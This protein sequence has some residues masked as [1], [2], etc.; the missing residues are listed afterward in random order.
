MINVDKKKGFCM[1]SGSGSDLL[2]EVA[3]IAASFCKANIKALKDVAG[4]APAA[5]KETESLLTAAIKAGCV[6]AL[7]S[8]GAT[9]EDTDDAE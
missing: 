8:V 9:E 1:L 7:A 5:A 2:Q 4:P 6:A 3:Y